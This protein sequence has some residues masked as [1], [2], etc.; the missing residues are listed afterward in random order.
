[1]KKILLLLFFG[2]PFVGVA[3]QASWLL[4]PAESTITYYAKHPLHRWSGENSKLKGIAKLQEGE[5]LPSQLAIIATVRD[6]DSQNENRD[7]HALEVLDA[8]DFP[9]VKFY[10]NQFE[11]TNSDS[12]VL[13]GD[14]E[15]HGVKV[16]KV[17]TAAFNKSSDGFQLQ[18]CFGFNASDFGLRL[19]S[20][21]LARIDDA[22]QIAFDVRFSPQIE[23]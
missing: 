23:E 19:P 3:Q 21:M 18:G 8:L 13:Q 7:A 9:D 11:A 5:E 20:F 14:L 12:L 15:F 1:M 4:M 2:V 16:S 10:C 22:I 17:I 6:F